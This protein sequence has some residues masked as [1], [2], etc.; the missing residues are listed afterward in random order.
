MHL[1][2]SVSNNINEWRDLLHVSEAKPRMPL[3]YALGGA[4]FR[5]GHSLSGIDLCSRALQANPT[6]FQT[7]Y[8]KRE[9]M[10]ALRAVDVA[11]LW[12]SFAFTSALM[13]SFSAV[14]RRKIVSLMYSLPGKRGGLKDYLRGLTVRQLGNGLG[15]IIVMTSEQERMANE[16]L[17]NIVPVIKLRLGVDTCFYR[18][19]SLDSV[20]PEEHRRDVTELLK[21][22]YVVMPGDELR[23]NHDAIEFVERTGH[24][25][26]RISQIAD[27]SNIDLMKERIH[28]L[29]LRD[30][31]FVFEK[32]DH[33]FLRFLLQ[34]ASAY[35][36]LVDSSWQPAGWTVACESLAS[37]LPIIVY[38]GLVS[39]ELTTLGATSS[40][41]R[42]VP[43]GD[44]DAFV[45]EFSELLAHARGSR[46]VTDQ[47]STFAKD[48]LDIEVTAPDFVARIEHEFEES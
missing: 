31:V 43:F 48:K 26:V 30:R 45:A 34:H 40:F 11:I 28:E 5:A 18:I 9:I 23:C 21:G 6:L 41:L 38:E 42:S 37:G 46:H 16:Y 3:P 1:L 29:S 4:F 36:G 27:K 39:R 25:L 33:E 32:I 8:Q 44:M 20:I 47:S 22:S 14:S 35:V 19:R 12:G 17:E 7:I 13:C 24:R 15:G 10:S 2:S